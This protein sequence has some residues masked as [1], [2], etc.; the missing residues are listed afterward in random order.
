MQTAEIGPHRLELVQGDITTESVDAIANAANA[1]LR[2]GG[3]V[4]GAIHR[5]AGPGLLADLRERYPDGT[6]T[7]TA[8]AT[9]GHEL[10]ARWILHAVGP[11]WRGG[12]H[13]EAELLAD[14][15]RSCLRL[16]DDL[17]ARSVA[18][19]AISI[20]IY[21]YPGPDGATVAIR[22]TAEHLAGQTSLDVI[23]FVLFSDETHDLFADALVRW[24]TD[25]SPDPAS[26]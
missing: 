2:G 21:G 22:A 23:R 19:P 14:A 15:Y 3:G 20:G 25:R 18:F 9:G 11:I 16:A 7:G 12:D 10:R 17:G 4:D 6:P 24:Q 26:K 5:A 13:E 8:V 1:S